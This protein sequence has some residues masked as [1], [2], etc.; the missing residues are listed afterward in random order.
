[1]GLVST[2][3]VKDCCGKQATSHSLIGQVTVIALT[4][5]CIWRGINL[6]QG[7][8]QGKKDIIPITLLPLFS[9]DW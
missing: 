5:S 8:E 3:S 2:E 1:M 4:M 9:C 7:L 6:N